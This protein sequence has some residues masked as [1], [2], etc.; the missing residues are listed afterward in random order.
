MYLSPFSKTYIVDK[1]GPDGQI[2]MKPPHTPKKKDLDLN[3]L[4]PRYV[5]FR[6]LLSISLD[7]SYFTCTWGY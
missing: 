7:L 3:L 5:L 4:I 6:K 2:V 1:S